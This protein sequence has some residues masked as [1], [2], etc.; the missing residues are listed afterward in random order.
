MNRRRAQPFFSPDGR[1]LAFFTNDAL[2]KVALAGG[3]ALTIAEIVTA[4]GGAWGLDGAIVF[5]PS[6]TTGL[7]RVSSSGG[8]QI[9]L[10]ELGDDERSSLAV[11]SPRRE[12]RAF[13]LP[14]IEWR[15]R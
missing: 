3:A 5:T 1:W 10:T 13:C 14:S 8:E 15:L 7:Y 6:R 9:K 2:K 4:R 11:V 12:G